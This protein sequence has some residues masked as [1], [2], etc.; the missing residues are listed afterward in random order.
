M[1]SLNDVMKNLAEVIELHLTD[2][3]V[4]AYVVPN[5]ATFPCVMLEPVPIDYAQAFAAGDDKVI[6]MAY[7]LVGV[8][9]DQAG[10]QVQLNTLITGWGP[11]S[12]RQAVFETPRLGL[13]DGTTAFAQGAASFTGK[14][15]IGDVTAVGAIVKILVH[16]DPRQYVAE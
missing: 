11:H 1:A 16:T 12:I 4:Y 6:I 7:A 10:A 3:P 13:M 8:S 15:E 2:V 14:L 9:G 5:G